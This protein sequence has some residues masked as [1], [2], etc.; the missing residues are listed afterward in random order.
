[1]AL[2]DALTAHGL[3]PF[4]KTWSHIF[5]STALALSVAAVSHHYL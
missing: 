5:L 2:R 1:V 3:G 4:A